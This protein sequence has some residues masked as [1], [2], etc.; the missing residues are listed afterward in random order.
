MKVSVW[1]FGEWF[2]GALG[3]VWK[4]CSSSGTPVM[5]KSQTRCTSDSTTSLKVVNG[6]SVAKELELSR[7]PDIQSHVIGVMKA[8]DVAQ[9][10]T[11]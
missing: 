1:M 6:L 9:H 3:R 5:I 10:V 4:V 11:S 7:M 2:C 8:H